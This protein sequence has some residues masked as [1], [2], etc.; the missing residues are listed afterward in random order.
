MK[1]GCKRYPKVFQTY[2]QKVLYK[3]MISPKSLFYTLLIAPLAFVAT[4]FPAQAEE[5]QPTPGESYTSASFLSEDASISDEVTPV[6]FQEVEEDE[7]AQVQQR[8]RMP[9]REAF[10]PNYIGIG[11]N[12]GLDGDTA[13]GNTNFAINSRLKLSPEISFRPSAVIGSNASFL[14]PFTYDFTPSPG[15]RADQLNLTPYIGGGALFAT[16][17][18]TDN[19]LGGL[20]TAGVD[21]PISRELTANAGLNVGF[22]DGNTDWGLL[23]GVGYNFPGN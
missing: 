11:L 4:T 20:I 5:A 12:V 15:G 17:D 14:I 6:S 3:P 13:L 21:M 18:A 2:S 7:L 9:A 8:E 22:I 10:S 16:G 19:D 1:V 23:L